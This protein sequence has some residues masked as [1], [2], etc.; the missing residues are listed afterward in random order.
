MIDELT[1]PDHSFSQEELKNMRALFFE[2]AAEFR[3]VFDNLRSQIES[4]V[5]DGMILIKEQ[6]DISEEVL[7]QQEL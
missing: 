4:N 7:Y 5:E 3:N 1:N 6:E 2:E